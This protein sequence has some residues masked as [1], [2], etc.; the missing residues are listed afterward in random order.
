MAAQVRTRWRLMRLLTKHRG[1]PSPR[2]AWSSARS[3]TC[4]AAAEGC[5]TSPPAG[6]GSS[7][8]FSS[9]RLTFNLLIDNPTSLSYLLPSLS[10]VTSL[11]SIRIQI[12]V[13]ICTTGRSNICQCPTIECTYIWMLFGRILGLQASRGEK[14]E[15]L[16][17]FEPKVSKLWPACCNSLLTGKRSN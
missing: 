2:C 17:S 13:R 16:V 11:I 8:L 9:H 14:N 6:E 1:S 12:G 3:R 4:P 5:Y 10:T 15:R 7:P